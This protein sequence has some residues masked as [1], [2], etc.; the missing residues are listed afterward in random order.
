MV[1]HLGKIDYLCIDLRLILMIRRL[2]I[3]ILLLAIAISLHAQTE[4]FFSGD[5]YLGSS[6]INDLLQDQWGRIWIATQGGLTK[7]DGHEYYTYISPQIVS[8]QVQRLTK[9]QCN[10][11]L[12]GTSAGLQRFDPATLQFTTI[13]L[14]TG[15]RHQTKDVRDKTDCFVGA[16]FCRKNGDVLVATSGYGVFT[17]KSG[18]DHAWYDEAMVPYPELTTVNDIAE[19][20][21]GKL[22]FAAGECGLLS[23]KDGKMKTYLKGLKIK[24]VCQT[25]D[26]H[27]YA[28][29]EN[30]T[31]FHYDAISDCMVAIP[32]A[33]QLPV[34]RLAAL[35]DGSVLLATDGQGLFR[36]N[37]KSRLLQ[38]HRFRMEFTAS[39]N[40]KIGALLEDLSGNLWIGVN[41]HGLVLQTKTA[42]F[43]YIGP[44][45]TDLNLIGSSAV[46]ALYMD[47]NKTLWV[48]TDGDGLYKIDPAGHTT[49]FAKAPASVLCIC[50]DSRGQLYVG[51]WLNGC[52][53]INKQTGHYEQF[54]CTRRGE[55]VHI[56][57]ILCD[58]DDN[59]WMGTN[60]D[61]L[62]CLN[63]RTH[64]LQEYRVVHAAEASDRENALSNSWI[65]SLS[66][67]P[68]SQRLYIGMSSSLGCIDL[69]SRSFVSTFGR[70]CLLS[71]VA[72]NS[73]R[74]DRNGIVWAATS[75]GLYRI[76]GAQSAIVNY[77]QADGLSSNNLLSMEID[78]DGTLWIG[79][80]SGLCQF[81]SD[82]DFSTARSNYKVRN[83]FKSDG[84]QG[85]EFYKGASA[86]WGDG[87]LAFGGTG[88]MTV[89]SPQDITA[90]QA[91]LRVLLM[92]MTVSGQEVNTL[93]RSGLYQ[94]CDTIVSDATRFDL[95]YTDNSFTLSFSTMDYVQADGLHYE[96]AIGN[97]TVWQQ[98]PKGVNVLTLS[99]LAPDT[100]PICVRAVT[101]STMSEELKFIV[102]VHPAWYASVYAKIA[103]CIL[104]LLMI[105]RYLRRR[106]RS[107]QQRLRVQEHIHAAQMREVEGNAGNKA[108]E[109]SDEQ[110]IIKDAVEEI[111]EGITIPTPDERLLE[112][113]IRVVNA[114][115]SDSG[116][117]VEQIA[118]EVGLSRSH[119]HR[120]MKELTGESTS[121]F[122]RNIRL[123]RAAY[124]LEGGRHSI[125]EVMYACGFDSP[126]GFSTRFKNFYGVSPSEY[127]REH[128]YSKTLKPTELS[129]KEY[130]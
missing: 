17:L 2:Y 103:Y 87:Q 117:S 64:Q 100:Y 57:S 77:R 123:K 69:H 46:S 58:Q 26:G 68:D 125:A 114:H 55:A 28:S 36:Y 65:N 111:V 92:G 62:K 50:E 42:N 10:R 39:G 53:S 45:S 102:V 83:Y 11:L 85:N 63:L 128:S 40:T 109:K 23:L 76:Q 61:G 21:D 93:T 30:G 48:G 107:E 47:G 14:M 75:Q 20:P 33:G 74:Q 78:N 115:L 126:P 127:M 15:T 8:D 106:R 1:S 5:E 70:N 59:L 41:Q 91:N 72:V 12:V 119:L 71:G 32:V 99:H 79:T 98:L 22:W 67:S 86:I 105:V 82:N 112:R 122:V 84:L 118:S 24:C 130:D 34:T 94:V 89:F 96:Y 25:I 66:L 104:I 110:R 35:S 3:F 29:E 38:Q 121:E 101:G 97:D 43:K 52:G 124:L 9:D 129:E 7:Y 13:H 108:E 6:T 95:A 73:V 19:M 4:R 18:D 44:R 51:T 54:D 37:V 120:K 90:K 27:L 88:G 16:L 31:L 60:G 81:I 49:H 116:L 56:M 113:V 80:S